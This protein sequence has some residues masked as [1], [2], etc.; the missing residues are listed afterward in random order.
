[1]TGYRVVDR[2]YP[3]PYVAPTLPV[4][5]ERCPSVAPEPHPGRWRS[6]GGRPG[7]DGLHTWQYCGA[8]HPESEYEC[9]HV[10]EREHGHDGPHREAFEW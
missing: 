7:H 8:S 6:C 3:A 2:R 10:C 1:M 9:G 5:Q 4:P